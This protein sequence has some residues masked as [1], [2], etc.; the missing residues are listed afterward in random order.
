VSAA[1]KREP[2]A[3][4]WYT[5]P[6]AVEY[7]RCSLTTIK[8]AI[9]SGALRPDSPSRPGFRIHR[10]RRATLDAWLTGESSNGT[11]SQG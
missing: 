6:E 11:A 3:R 4:E 5:T 9:A 7:T 1:E 2:V 8:R 10:F